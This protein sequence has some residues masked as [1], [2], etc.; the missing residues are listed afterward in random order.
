MLLFSRPFMSDSLWP[1]GLQHPR[2]PRNLSVSYLF[3]LLYSSWG[4]PS[5]YTRVVCHSL[6]QGIIFCQN[7]PLW[8]I[9]LGWPYTACL[10]TSL[11]YTS[12]FATTRQWFMKRSSISISKTLVPRFK[13][14]Y[15]VQN[16]HLAVLELSLKYNWALEVNNLV[17]QKTFWEMYTLM[18]IT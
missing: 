7:S 6:L 16:K 2:P 18:G 14:T 5:K 8:P 13:K 4:S 12:P 15:I 9:C 11:S 17:K 3:V 1:H 10:I